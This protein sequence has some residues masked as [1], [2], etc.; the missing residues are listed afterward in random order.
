MDSIQSYILKKEDLENLF[1]IL[2]SLQQPCIVVQPYKNENNEIADFNCVF[3]NEAASAS[4]NTASGIQQGKKLSSI[5]SIYNT[6]NFFKDLNSV[7]ET[8]NQKSILLEK[9]EPPNPS[10]EK[11][12]I[13]AAKLGGF[14]MLNW[15]DSTFIQTQAKTITKLQNSNEELEQ[16]AYV[17][18]H[19]LQEPIRMVISFT[20][21]LQRRYADKLDSDAQEF[22]H[23]AVDGAKRMKELID[24]LLDYSRVI[25]TKEKF[26]KFSVQSII[27][28]ICDDL[29]ELI[30]ETG[31]KIIYKDLPDIYSDETM[32]TRV[33]T[34]LLSN[35][36][37]YRREKNP[38]VR[39]SAR[40]EEAGWLFSVKD[41]GIGIDE[42]YFD[43]IFILF[44][45][46]HGKNEYPGTGIGL[47]T[48]KKIVENLG[49]KIWLESKINDGTT[50]Y[51]TIPLRGS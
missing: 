50:F 20:Q 47:A 17:A 30:N 41:N 23:Y 9:T 7:Y 27:K 48:S 46:L 8:G 31:I 49:G 25:T 28:N 18:S 32:I 29:E 26:K 40:Q 34:N 12:K 15:I 6:K 35:S 38:E 45:R 19:D 22:I 10:I 51:F 37:K 14:I 44:K 36:I 5:L 16:F 3:I 13:N 42:K 21:L 11:L 39:I 43:K 33:F 2:N 24:T 1:N 4:F